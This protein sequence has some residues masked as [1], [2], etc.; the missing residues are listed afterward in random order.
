[1]AYDLLEPV[2]ATVGDSVIDMNFIFKEFIV[3]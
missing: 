1:M 2:P 3:W